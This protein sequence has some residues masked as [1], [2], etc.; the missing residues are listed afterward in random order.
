MN[1]GA[2][3]ARSRVPALPAVVVKATVTHTITYFGFGLLAQFV[4]DYALLSP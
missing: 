1:G 3:D 2:A 4:F